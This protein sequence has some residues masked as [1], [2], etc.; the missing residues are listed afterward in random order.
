VGGW[1]WDMGYRICFGGL[2]RYR[3]RITCNVA[4]DTHPRSAWCLVS[5]T[6]ASLSLS[7]SWRLLALNPEDLTPAC[8]CWILVTATAPLDVDVAVGPPL[9]NYVMKHLMG[10]ARGSPPLLPPS[11]QQVK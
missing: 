4:H 5:D 10:A 8:W 9:I 2:A 7:L 1:V 11:P 6:W 3:Y